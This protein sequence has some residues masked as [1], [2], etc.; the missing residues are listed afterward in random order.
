MYYPFSLVRCHTLNLD[1]ATM[2]SPETVETLEQYKEECEKCLG[3]MSE[4][5][6]ESM[7]VLIPQEQKPDSQEIIRN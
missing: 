4:T 6:N 7:D 1:V 3:R 5:L 2:F